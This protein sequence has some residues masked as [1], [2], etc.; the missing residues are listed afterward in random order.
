MGYIPGLRRWLAVKIFLKRSFAL[1]CMRNSGR[2]EAAYRQFEFG[3]RTDGDI[4]LHFEKQ[5]IT[6][7]NNRLPKHS[8][9]YTGSD[10]NLTAVFIRLDVSMW[11]MK[12]T[13][14]Y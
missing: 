5:S 4:L 8:I 1:M 13:N 12:R 14:E 3:K 6:T 9:E 11:K 7:Y 10:V 2:P